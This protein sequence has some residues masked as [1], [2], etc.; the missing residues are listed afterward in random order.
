MYDN[1]TWRQLMTRMNKE[2]SCKCTTEAFRNCA[3]LGSR[4]MEILQG[5]IKFGKDTACAVLSF[6]SS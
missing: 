6:C 1:I 5:E 4:N 2:P 3:K